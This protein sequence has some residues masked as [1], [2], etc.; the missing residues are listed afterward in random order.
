MAVGVVGTA[1][2]T[3]NLD[4]LAVNQLYV[5]GTITG[6]V[7]NT[8]TETSASEVLTSISCPGTI[9]GSVAN[10]STVGVKGTVTG[11]FLKGTLAGI[12]ANDTVD[13]ASL[14]GTSF[15]SLVGTIVGSQA[16]GLGATPVFVG[17]SPIF[18]F[19]TFGAPYQRA[20]ADG[21]N[22]FVS[23]GTTG[24]VRITTIA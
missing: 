8:G 10:I 4:V 15:Y 18:D 5:A 19:G 20:A 21:T 6:S 1:G 13:F 12:A 22:T 7:Q 2:G 16:H 11:S 14:K 17:I 23:A 3:T 24:T 9:T